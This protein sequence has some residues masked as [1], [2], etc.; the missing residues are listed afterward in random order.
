LARAPTVPQD[1]V[2]NVTVK[3]NFA[4]KFERPGF[5]GRHQKLVKLR[6]G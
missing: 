3:W 5:L 2:D 6:N 1:E 4:E